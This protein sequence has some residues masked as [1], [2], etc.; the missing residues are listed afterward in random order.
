M[1]VTTTPRVDGG[2]G[3]G[4]GGSDITLPPVEV[5]AKRLPITA[6]SNVTSV[7]SPNDGKTQ[8]GEQLWMRKWKLTVGTPQGDKA[9]DL[10]LLDFE[11]TINQDRYKVPWT[12]RIK[13]WNVGDNIISRMNKE[14]TKVYLKAGYQEPSNQYGDL[15]AGQ[16]N[17][18]K[19]GR[20]NATDTFVE[21]FASTFEDPLRSAIVNTW[22]PVG[23]AKKDEIQ[24][25]A[26]ALAPWGITLGQVTDLKDANTKAPR[27]K[28]MFG[29]A[30]DYMRDIE[31]TQKAHFFTDTDGRLHL[32]KDSEA[33]ALGSETIPI[34]TSKTGLI[35][36]PTTTLDGAA[37]VQCLL[38]PRITPG[39]RIRIA[40]KTAHKKP[41]EAITKYTNVDTSVLVA[42]AYKLSL[43]EF[44][45]HADGT[46]TVGAVRHQ[47]ANR[48][49]PWY[50]H[51]ITL[52]VDQVP[53]LT[54]SAGAA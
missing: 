4:G 39:T 53:G 13:I 52:K 8:Q 20:Q 15:F 2:S 30:A 45:F 33:L 31:R 41:D 24:A 19:H 5:T 9:M 37:E 11:F 1:S 22:L 36:V 6:P 18:F 49:N 51:I 34:L 26:A 21:I 25:V 35:D 29:M 47:G 44:N 48:G 40:N 42:D 27:G 46:Y 10:S 32:L 23:Y 12:G 43:T 28:L 7:R 50:S 3:G 14:L 17:Y 54:T 16:I 38:N